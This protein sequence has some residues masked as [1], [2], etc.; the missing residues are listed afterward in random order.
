MK[1]TTQ[2]ILTSHQP[3]RILGGVNG[4]D[5]IDGIMYIVSEGFAARFGDQWGLICLAAKL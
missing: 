5:D 1:G 2:L 3:R 4:L